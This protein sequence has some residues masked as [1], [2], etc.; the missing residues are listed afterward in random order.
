MKISV[1]VSVADMLVLIYWYRQKYCLGE[2]IGMGW[3]QI[4]PT[5]HNILFV[6]K[7]SSQD[8]I[9]PLVT[10]LSKKDCGGLEVSITV[11]GS[12]FSH[13]KTLFTHL[14]LNFA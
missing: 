5:V 14:R 4:N 8:R 13:P 6:T 11:P 7:L 3:T 10:V 9:D 1:S 2:Y 12:I